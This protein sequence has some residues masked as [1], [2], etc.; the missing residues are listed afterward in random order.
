MR[1]VQVVFTIT[2]TAALAILLASGC[3]TKSNEDASGDQAHSATGSGTQ[4]DL[5]KG[6]EPVDLD[7][8]NFTTRI[9]N[10]Y[11]PMDPG[12]RW[13]YREIDEEGAELKVVV[14]V[15]NQT[16]KIA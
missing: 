10:L 16:K 13:T 8:K 4:V 15:S 1:H 6:S 2:I 7:P 5:P 3:N 14:T 9:D 12:T 11:W